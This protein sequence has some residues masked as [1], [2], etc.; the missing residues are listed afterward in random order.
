MF[1]HHQ[2]HEAPQRYVFDILKKTSGTFDSQTPEHQP[3]ETTNRPSLSFL[4]V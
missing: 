4:V 3:D 2:I 1:A